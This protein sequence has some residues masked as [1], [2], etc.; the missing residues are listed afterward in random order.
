MFN[1]ILLIIDILLI[2]GIIALIIIWFFIC[3]RRN[4]KAI[5]YTP[6]TNPSEEVLPINTNVEYGVP[7]DTTASQ[8][9]PMQIIPNYYLLQVL[10]IIVS[11]CLFCFFFVCFFFFMRKDTEL[12]KRTRVVIATSTNH[13]MFWKHWEGGT[14]WVETLGR[15][16]RGG[17]N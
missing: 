9:V 5:E 1:W 8:I 15:D 12:P 6:T 14:L 11:F 16:M 10:K 13:V 2:L 7:L 4:V 3:R 17:I